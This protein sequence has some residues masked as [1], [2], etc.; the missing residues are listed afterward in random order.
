MNLRSSLGLI[1]LFLAMFWV[2]GLMLALD[3]ARVDESLVVPTL[4]KALDTYEID[5]VAVERTAK[6]KDAEDFRFTRK[7]E[8][9]SLQQG[10]QSIKVETFRI[11]DLI[12]EVREARRDEEAGVPENPG[13]NPPQATVTLV[14]TRKKKA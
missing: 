4:G 3:R 10:S 14:A 11:R 12:R 8:N 9:W 2:F 5:T 7:G 1:G 6:G 13:L